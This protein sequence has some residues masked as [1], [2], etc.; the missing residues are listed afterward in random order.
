MANRPSSSAAAIIGPQYCAPASHPVDLIIT[1]ERTLRD[2]FTVTDIND[3]IVFTVKSPLVTIV[4]PRE[5][6][7]LHDAHGNPILHLRRALL[8]A[9]DC[10]EA[11]SG[12][13][14]EPKDLIFTRKR[15]SL[16]Q[17][18]TTLNVFLANNTTKVCDFKVKANLSARSWVVYIGESDTV[19]A[20]IK[21]KFGSVFSREKF[22]VTVSPNIDYAFIVGLIVTLDD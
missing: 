1:K 19:A 4:T 7:F 11:F 15:S 14:T 10:W 18:R 6:R 5:H 2:N 9:S 22:M 21:K 8:A 3:S 20:K 13:S 12:K 16:F 17:L